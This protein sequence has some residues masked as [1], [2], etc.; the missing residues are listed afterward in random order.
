MKAVVIRL[1]SLGD[2]VL[3][4][5]VLQILFDANWELGFVTR[6]EY[7]PLFY[8]DP[9]I[10]DIF[11]F[12]GFLKT[13]EQIRSFNPDRVLDLQRSQRSMLLS[14]LL[15]K[16]VSRTR[17][18]SIP[19]R[20]MVMLGLGDRRPR[21]VIDIQINALR[22]MG[23]DNANTESNS[24]PKLYPSESGSDFG[25]KIVSKLSKPIAVLHPG[26]R[27]PLKKWGYERFLALATLLS[28]RGFSVL[29]IADDNKFDE[30]ITGR[31]ELQQLVGLLSCAELFVGNDSGPVHIAASLGTPTLSI[32]GPTHPALGFAPRGQFANSITADLS[33][34]PCTLH[35]SGKCRLKSQRCFQ[36]LSPEFVAEKAIEVYRWKYG[37]DSAQ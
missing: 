34:S 12:D 1:S 25:Q 13:A 5:A 19:R 37:K 20:A 10:S 35:G 30:R 29:I 14:G 21:S 8:S 24:L 32:F 28:Q 17:K 9:R 36:L 26:A 4:T 18:R 3:S 15:G 27:H 31:L 2:V 7:I 6:P 16:P 22:N 23:I 33:C 11:G